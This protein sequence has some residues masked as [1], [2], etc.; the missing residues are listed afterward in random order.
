M[1]KTVNKKYGKSH[2]K[3]AEETP[4]NKIFIDLIGPYK[5]RRKGKD[6]LILKSV[7]IIYAITKWFEIMQYSNK[8]VMAI[9]NLVE[10][11]CLVRYPWPV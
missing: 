3:I 5:T 10:T 9:L 11:T 1:Y 7:T 2:V 8:K 6:H 4:W